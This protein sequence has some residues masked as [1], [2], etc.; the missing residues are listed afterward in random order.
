[1]IKH[2]Y[3]FKV[4]EGYDI[5]E[6]AKHILTLKDYCPTIKEIEVGL[7]FKHASNSYDLCE[8]VTF[9]NK[10]DFEAFGIN[11]YHAGMRLYLGER[12]EGVKIDFEI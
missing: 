11:E 12:T 4:K 6:I 3:L 2:I 5:N 7:D 1:M 10:E 8:Y 9:D